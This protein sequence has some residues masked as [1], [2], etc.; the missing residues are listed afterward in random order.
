M[1]RSNPKMAQ[2]QECFIANLVNTLCDPFKS[3]GLLPG[4][5]I[6]DPDMSGMSRFSFFFIQMLVFFRT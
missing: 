5:L 3:A 4:I 2:L 1:D 6:E